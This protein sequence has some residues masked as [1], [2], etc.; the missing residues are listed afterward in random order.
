M[1][2]Y[3]WKCLF[4]PLEDKTLPLLAISKYHFVFLIFKPSISNFQLQKPGS[5]IFWIV[6]QTQQAFTCW[7]L[8]PW[9]FLSPRTSP[10]FSQNPIPVSEHTLFQPLP[11]PLPAS[12]PS[13]LEFHLTIGSLYKYLDSVTAFKVLSQTFSPLILTTALQGTQGSCY[14][15]NFTTKEPRVYRG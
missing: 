14:L 7:P 1:K 11:Y 2:W 4:K 13:Y 9:E 6:D 10:I 8:P 15:P 3:M 12:G 5:W